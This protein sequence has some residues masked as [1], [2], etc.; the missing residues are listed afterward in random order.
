MSLE[1]QKAF[2]R[3]MVTQIHPFQAN[4]KSKAINTAYWRQGLQ[5]L[6]SKSSRSDDGKSPS[7]KDVRNYWSRVIGVEGNFDLSNLAIQQ[8]CGT[9]R[10]AAFPHNA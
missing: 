5:C 10:C 4:A 9:H 1:M 6:S 8:W 3:V 7:P 2:L